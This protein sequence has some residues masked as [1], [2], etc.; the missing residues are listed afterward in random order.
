MD[1]HCHLVRNCKLLLSCQ[2][3][4]VTAYNFRVSLRAESPT[5][6][7]LPDWGGGVKVSLLDSRQAIEVARR[8]PNYC[9]GNPIFFR[10]TGISRAS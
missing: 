9:T 2:S 3:S 6:C 7:L 10:Q 1:V 8:S 4:I 5:A